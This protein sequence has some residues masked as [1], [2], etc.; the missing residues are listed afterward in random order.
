MARLRAK[1]WV[2]YLTRPERN[3]G[4]AASGRFLLIT[5]AL[6]SRDCVSCCAEPT[7]GEFTHRLRRVGGVALTPDHL[8]R[9]VEQKSEAHA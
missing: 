4:S 2:A 1:R 6:L 3:F 5:K 7:Q 9:R 8:T